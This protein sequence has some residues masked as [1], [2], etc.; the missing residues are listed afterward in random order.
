MQG[1]LTRE[2]F[3]WLTG[4]LCQLSRIPFDPGLLLQRFPSPHSVGQFIE[5]ARA[6]GMKT[7]EAR[8]GSSELKAL[9]Q[10]C[11][12]FL[13][14]PASKPVILVKSDGPSSSGLSSSAAFET[15]IG[16]A[17]LKMAGKDDLSDKDRMTLALAGQKAEHN[18]ANVKCGIMDQAASGLCRPGHALLLDCRPTANGGYNTAHVR[19]N[20][21]D[22]V[23][24]VMDTRLAR[25]LEKSEY[26]E[27]RG[28]CEEAVALL[29]QKP[30]LARGPAG[31]QRG[32]AHAQQPAAVAARARLRHQ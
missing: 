9:R 22:A 5:A 28:Q 19:V 18:Y 23:F 27:R 32:R 30:A 16:L 11:V 31:V 17:A 4:S 20:F 3:V 29:K 25:K 14:A 13:K 6:L 24:V 8:L 26:N 1:V 12:G 7:G 21:P 15:A 2:N 10:P